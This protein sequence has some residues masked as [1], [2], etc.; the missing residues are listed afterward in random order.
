MVECR[1]TTAAK[2]SGQARLQKTSA[3]TGNSEVHSWPQGDF[4][5]PEID[6]CFT[7]ESRLSRGSHRLPVLI[8]SSHSW[9]WAQCDGLAYCGARS[10][11]IGKGSATASAHSFMLIAACHE[12]VTRA[13][14]T[15]R[16]EKFNMIPIRRAYVCEQKSKLDIQGG[17]VS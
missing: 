2:G 17:R 10:L 6:F 11:L 7:P 14:S 4:Q 13:L 1:W 12:Y 3:A 5:R 15:C 8:Q 9:R 16:I